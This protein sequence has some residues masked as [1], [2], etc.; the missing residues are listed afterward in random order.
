[1][2][3]LA[4][5][6]ISHR[7]LVEKELDRTR[8]DAQVT[9]ILLAGSV[10]RG[11]TSPSSD[12]DLCFLLHDGCARVF[13]AETISGILVERK[14]ADAVQA[15]IK[16]ER[17]P[18]EVYAY[19][20]GCILMDRQ[21]ILATLT[22]AARDRFETYKM[23][24]EERQSIAAWL[25]SAAIKIK[26]ARS[27]GDDLKAAFVATTIAWKILEG[28]WAVN[29]RPMPPSGCVIPHLKDLHLQPIVADPDWFRGLFQAN[30]Q[31]R[32][33]TALA[34]INGLVPLLSAPTEMA[35]R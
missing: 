10:A 33:E 12:L 11:D 15:R 31:V 22:V 28:M 29:N 8:N 19:L 9:G 4:F 26:A 6:H 30:A 24:N 20:D 16:I 34:L 27:T 23:P 14:Y 13:E 5:T 1:M 21:G 17:N 7:I 35:K 25:R 18:M 2:T 32:I 3:Y